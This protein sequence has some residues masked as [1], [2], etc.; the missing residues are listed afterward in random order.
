ML[1]L[2][3]IQNSFK[4]YFQNEPFDHCVIKNFFPTDLATELENEFLEY[5]HP[6]WYEYN[7]PLEFKK[8]TNRA[9][10]IFN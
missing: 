2:E 10:G 9:R 3:N 6:D 7:N 8:T 5:D 4:Q 1:D